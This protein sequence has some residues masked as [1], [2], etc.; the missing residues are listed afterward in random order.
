[1]QCT[2]TFEQEFTVSY[3]ANFVKGASLCDRVEI[4]M[5]HGTPIRF[6]I[7]LP[8]PGQ[9]TASMSVDSDEVSA[10]RF[11]LAPKIEDE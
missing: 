3:L 6:S 7:P 8:C 9:Q 10:L 2:E 11:Y 4:A 1:M 5:T